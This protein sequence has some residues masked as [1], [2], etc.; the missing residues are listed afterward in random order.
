MECSFLWSEQWGFLYQIFFYTSYLLVFSQDNLSH[1]NWLWPCPSQYYSTTHI[2]DD[3]TP[4][5]F[6]QYSPSLLFLPLL[7]LLH[8][9]PPHPPAPHPSTVPSSHPSISSPLLFHSPLTTPPPPLSPFPDNAKPKNPNPFQPKKPSHEPIST[10]PSHRLKRTAPGG[11][12]RSCLV[13][14]L[15]LHFLPLLLL[16]RLP[17][18]LPLT[19]GGRAPDSVFHLSFPSLHLYIPVCKLSAN[20]SVKVSIYGG[21]Q[22]VMGGRRGMVRI[23]AEAGDGVTGNG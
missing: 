18:P 14:A 8:H 5:R 1:H 4:Y 17:W 7:P 6:R 11:A 19:I 15:L 16:V 13:L 12:R 2:G 10:Q 20:R 21:V 9:H 23:P 22:R 3:R